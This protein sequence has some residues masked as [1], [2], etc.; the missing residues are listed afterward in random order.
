[1]S[2]SNRVILLSFNLAKLS[3]SVVT[4]HANF[5]S[6]IA[7]PIKSLYDRAREIVAV[8]KIVD[9]RYSDDKRGGENDFLHI[10][11]S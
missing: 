6:F 11:T 2:Y 7:V 10:F 5:I 3:I 8:V 9:T 4:E 1:M